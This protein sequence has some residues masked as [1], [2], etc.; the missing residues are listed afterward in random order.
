MLVKVYGN[1]TCKQ[2]AAGSLREEICYA[3]F[4]GVRKSVQLPFQ[5]VTG[6]R[7][8]IEDTELDLTDTSAPVLTLW[9]T[10]L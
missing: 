5:N 9:V 1:G 4:M 8:Q 7:L 3:L 2:L 6:V 10:R